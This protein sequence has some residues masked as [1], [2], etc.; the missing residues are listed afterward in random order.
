MALFR[1]GS[2]FLEFLVSPWLKK[3][4]GI[5]LVGSVI[6][7]PLAAYFMP[8]KDFA[9][10]FIF[11]IFL[12][13]VIYIFTRLLNDD[14]KMALGLTIFIGSN[15]ILGKAYYIITAVM[16][17]SPKTQSLIMERLPFLAPIFN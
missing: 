7:M 11:L 15:F 3:Y 2:L 1:T 16:F 17:F 12:L 5:F 4:G 6:A 10:P 13:M 8:R 9:F 14:K